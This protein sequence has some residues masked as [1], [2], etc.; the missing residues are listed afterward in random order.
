MMQQL[1]CTYSELLAEPYDEL[2]VFRAFM[3]GTEDAERLA[4]EKE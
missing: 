2:Q 4:S 3:T 1:H